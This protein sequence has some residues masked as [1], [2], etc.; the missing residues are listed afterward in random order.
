MCTPPVNI[1]NH[2]YGLTGDK[3][4]VAGFVEAKYLFVLIVMSHYSADPMT[5]DLSLFI[6]PDGG[7]FI[8]AKQ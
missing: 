2:N 8:E 5:H 1:T 7:S 4:L 6:F 3:A